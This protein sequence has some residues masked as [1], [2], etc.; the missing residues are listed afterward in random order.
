MKIVTI[1]DESYYYYGQYVKGRYYRGVYGGE[2]YRKNGRFIKV[3]NSWIKIGNRTNIS[4]D[5]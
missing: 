1:A 4:F 3:D 2:N 5:N